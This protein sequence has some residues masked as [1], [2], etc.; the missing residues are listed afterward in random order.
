MDKE[1][2]TMKNPTAQFF[3]GTTLLP[4]LLSLTLS[5]SAQETE[6]QFLSGHDK[7]DAV[8]WKFFC[9]SGANSG[10]WDEPVGAVAMGR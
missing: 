7:D 6:V 4:L 9:T 8:P 3:T 5:V 1:N 10:V 2:P